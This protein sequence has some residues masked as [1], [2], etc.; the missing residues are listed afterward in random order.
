MQVSQPQAVSTTGGAVGARALVAHIVFRFD[1]GGL[2]NGIVN[3]VNSLPASEFDHVIIA[4]SEVSDFKA[5]IRRSDVR[6]IALH[7]KLGKDLGAYVR[8]WKLLRELKPAI[9]HTRNIGTMDC[10]PFAWLAGVPARI[11]G[12][13][14]W[15]VHDPDG[16]NP[17]YRLMRRVLGPFAHSFVTVS[18]DLADWLVRVV[19]V[20]SDKVAHICNGVDTQ[21]F[22]PNPSARAALPADVFPRGCIVVGTVTRLMAI[23]DPLNLVRAFIRVRRELDGKGPDVRLAL[24]GDG[25]LR[26]DVERELQAAHCESFA[27]LAGSRDDVAELLPAFDVFVLGS[28]REGI[29]NTVLEAM[30]SGVPVIASATGGNLELIRDRETGLL[31]PPG[32]STALAAALSS[33][34]T[35]PTLRSAH[36]QASRRRAE[37]LYSLTGMM[38][39]YRELY[40]RHSAQALE[41]V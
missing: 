6:V 28:L 25:P 24:I 27:W 39:R 34:V 5:R 20:R 31:V 13:H 22:R 29:S 17:K 9:V 16:K 10:L 23:K 21:R 8:L 14:G 19:G 41:T 38:G 7:K 18:R 15:D 32:D 35:D 12:E 11:H 2:E 36:G 30:S 4:M 40:V 37:E 1:Y 26:P 3:I 33:Y